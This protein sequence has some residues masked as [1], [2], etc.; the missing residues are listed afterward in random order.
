M[1]DW[2]NGAEARTKYQKIADALRAS[3][4]AWFDV[5]ERET[6]DAAW[7]FQQ[8]IR[9]GRRAAFRPAGSFEASCRGLTVTARFVGD[10]E[11]SDDY[12]RGF[13]AGYE[14]ALEKTEGG[15]DDAA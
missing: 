14:K 7:S 9:T 13:Q 2:Y 12:R 10:A 3:P 4:G 8:A 5:D 11:E 1:S 15:S 6:Q